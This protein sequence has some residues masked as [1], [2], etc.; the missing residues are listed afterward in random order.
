MSNRYP[1]GAF[2]IG[3]AAASLAIAPFGREAIGEALPS[4]V[5]ADNPIAARIYESLAAGSEE[6]GSIF[7]MLRNGRLE[8]LKGMLNRGYSALTVSAGYRGLVGSFGDIAVL[9]TGWKGSTSETIGRSRFEPASLLPPD[10]VQALI[11]ERRENK[12]HLTAV[13]GRIIF[14]GTALATELWLFVQ[15][16]FELRRSLAASLNVRPAML[17]IEKA[18]AIYLERN[19]FV[20]TPDQPAVP[21]FNL[22]FFRVDH[23]TQDNATQVGPNTLALLHSILDKT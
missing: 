23:L 8:Q 12:W 18:R 5:A 17:P 21:D 1:R 2:L 22:E 9:V 13:G 7:D 20:L 6:A 3:G 15:I 16:S 4:P 11:T 14:N 19:G 10:Q